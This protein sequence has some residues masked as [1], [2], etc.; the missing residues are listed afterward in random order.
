[1]ELR[2]QS[3]SK[4]AYAKKR[5]RDPIPMA[6]ESRGYPRMTVTPKAERSIKNGHPWV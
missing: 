3:A 1:M 4:A 6:I 5:R 2:M